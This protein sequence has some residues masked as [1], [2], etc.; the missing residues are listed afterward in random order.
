MGRAYGTKVLAPHQTISHILNILK[1]IVDATPE[2]EMEKIT[3]V[4]YL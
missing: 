2:N 3:F 1:I 4:K